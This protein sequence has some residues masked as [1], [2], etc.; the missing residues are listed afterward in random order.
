[1]FRRSA[2]ARDLERG[3]AAGAPQV[4]DLVVALV[5]QARRV[6]PPLDVPAAVRPRCAH[7]LAHRQRHGT[8]GAVDLVG[9]LR[10]GGG[11]A[12][13]HDAALLEAPGVAVLGGGEL[14]N[15]WRHGSA[16]DAGTCAMLNAPV[17]STTAL[18]CQVALLGDDLVAVA[19]RRTDVDRAVRPQRRRDRFA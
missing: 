3:K 15:P 19:E 16:P 10:A 9:D 7:V 6:H 14:G 13:D 17:A 18:Q 11:R 12:D 2:I 5:V 8:P 1:M 4:L